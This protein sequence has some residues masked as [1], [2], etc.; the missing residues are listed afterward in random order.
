MTTQSHAII[1][2]LLLSKKNKPHLHQYALLG[3]VLPDLPMFIFFGIEAFILKHAQQQIW[4]ERYFLPQWQ[5]FF[6]LFN[7]IPLILFVMGIG[8]YFRS[9]A[10]TIC[11][12]S[13]LLHCVAD[14]FLHHDDAHRHFF[15]LS[16]FAF[17]SPIS[18]WDPAHYGHIVGVVELLLTLVASIF[19]FPRLQ[20][21]IT[22]GALVAVNLISV[23]AYV[24]FAV[25][26]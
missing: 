6:D 23:L 19:L 11:C 22:R 14:F 26:S 13:M 20:S 1:N 21:R 12:R 4:S 10:V 9:D 7:S 5:N 3:A 24:G 25:F 18:Y 2:V 8:Y 15:P 17:H 16:Q